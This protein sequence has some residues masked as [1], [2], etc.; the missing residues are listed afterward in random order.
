MP[1]LLLFLLYLLP[2]GLRAQLSQG[3][4]T[5]RE[6]T[7]LNLRAPE[8]DAALAASLPRESTVEYQLYFEP[9]ASLYRVAPGE[10]AETEWPQAQGG[11]VMRLQR[12]SSIR[13]HDLQGGRFTEQL[14][15]LGRDFLVQDALPTYA[16]QLDEARR[17][18]LGLPVLRATAISDG[19]TIVAWYTPAIPVATGP[20]AYSGLPGL[21]LE[22][23]I[24]NGRRLIQATQF[25]PRA[26]Q[27]ADFAPPTRGKAVTQ[28][29]MRQIREEKMREMGGD[30]GNIIRVFRN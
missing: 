11:R 19:D 15:F 25:D 28:A 21:I 12:P 8:G 23:D 27:P 2:C 6:T 1:Y 22:V 16:W 18:L 4:V 7:Q 3:G 14:D 20:A 26:T 5:Y 30:N 9:N 29:E 17:S 13:Y 10:A 24:D